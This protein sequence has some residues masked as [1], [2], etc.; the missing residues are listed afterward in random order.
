M[1]S[2]LKNGKRFLLLG[3]LL[4][5]SLLLLG[6]KNRE[7]TATIPS[8]REQAAVAMLKGST[9]AIQEKHRKEWQNAI[10]NNPLL[11]LRVNSVCIETCD[12]F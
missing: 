9:T 6:S 10:T 8:P 7:Q 1:V 11:L 2:L 4:F 12:N 3:I 5:L